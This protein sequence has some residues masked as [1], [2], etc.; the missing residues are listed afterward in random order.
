MKH[1]DLINKKDEY[2]SNLN[3]SFQ[4]SFSLLKLDLTQHFEEKFTQQIK[5]ASTKHSK[6]MKILKV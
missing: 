1:N 5:S 3:I 6:N 4:E 2:L